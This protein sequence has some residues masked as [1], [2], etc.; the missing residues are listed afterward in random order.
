MVDSLR[1]AG[2]AKETSKSEAPSRTRKDSA[3]IS[4]E[5]KAMSKSAS[6][7]QV[8]ARANALPETRQE[9]IAEVRE[10]IAN[11]YYDSAE[12]QDKLADKLVKDFWGD[13]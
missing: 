11:G 2:N 5:G 4:G 10:K 7:E 13:A 9:K 12:F 6:A 8:E 1:K 3:N